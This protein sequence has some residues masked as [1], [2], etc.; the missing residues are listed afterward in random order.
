MR[1]VVVARPGGPEAL[2]LA[3]RPV[4]QPGPGEV[5]VRVHASALNRADLLQR[6]GLYPA[7]PGAPQDVPG[8]EYAGEVDAMG[9]GAGLWAVGSR[10][11]GIVGGG[12]YAEY[13]TVHEREAMRIPQ[14]LSYEE[15]AAIPEAFLTAY[16]ALFRRLELEVGE[17]VLVHAV[18]SGVGTAAVQLA[19][20]A[21][22]T[23]I[24]TSRS[25]EKL[26]RAEEL[27][28]DVGIDIAKEDLAAALE[29]ATYGS[30]VNAVLDLVGGPILEASLRGLA[31]G[32]RVVVVGTVAGSRVELDLGLVLRR[33]IRI[34]GTVLRTRPLEEKIALAREFSNTVL[35]LLSSGKIRPVIDRVYP[36]SEIA[37]AHRQMEANESFGKI[38]LTW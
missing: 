33:R 24:G 23:V 16:D 4:P 31:Q 12:G 32:G 27:G 26:R 6:R 29:N 14:G 36:F 5:R 9:E 21:G 18:G 8:L 1:A 19:H 22:A 3:E 25:P 35:P 34:V 7:P 38:V 10:V 17:R 28:M 15:G 13:V 30:G 20:A 11:M 37:E 2:Q